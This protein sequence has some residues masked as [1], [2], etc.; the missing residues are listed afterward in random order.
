VELCLGFVLLETTN[1]PAFR[2]WTAAEGREIL[3]IACAVNA[4]TLLRR[5]KPDGGKPLFACPLAS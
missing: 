4:Q 5:D 1:L 2:R 3:A